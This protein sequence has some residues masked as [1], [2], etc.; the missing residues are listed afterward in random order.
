MCIFPYTPDVLLPFREKEIYKHRAL[1]YL[2]RITK[3]ELNQIFVMNSENSA[4]CKQF[5][6]KLL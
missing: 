3:V 1:D 6:P 5:F 4:E 2:M